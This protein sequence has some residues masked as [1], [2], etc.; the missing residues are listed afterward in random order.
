MWSNGNLSV[1]ARYWWRFHLHRTPPKLDVRGRRR[2]AFT[3]L[4]FVLSDL[5][6]DQYP[7]KFHFR[8]PA[9]YSLVVLPV[10]VIRFV[11]FALEAQGLSI[12][13]VAT[14]ISITLFALSGAMNVLLL[15]TTRPNLLLFGRPFGAEDDSDSSGF[16][17]NA[18]TQTQV[19]IMREQ[20]MAEHPSQLNLPMAMK[21]EQQQLDDMEHME[22]SDSGHSSGSGMFE[23]ASSQ[24]HES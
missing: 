22:E 20:I 10:S 13:S 7:Y 11:G 12:P 15:V 16:S 21:K 6:L 9:A 1:D 3:I 17:D 8:Y 19:T 18:V 4:A 14:F 2:R 5:H 24:R 23:G